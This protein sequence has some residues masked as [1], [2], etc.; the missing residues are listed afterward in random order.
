MSTRD[1]HR[2]PSKQHL[3]DANV[4]RSANEEDI[5]EVE[6]FDKASHIC[7]T[8]SE[9]ANSLVFVQKEAMSYLSDAA[10][11]NGTVVLAEKTNKNTFLGEINNF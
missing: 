4:D 2:D 11:H 9:S 8:R 3:R 10:G 6:S 5:G 1:Q 7:M